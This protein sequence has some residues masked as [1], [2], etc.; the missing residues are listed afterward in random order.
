MQCIKMARFRIWPF[1]GAHWAIWGGHMGVRDA[2]RWNLASVTT[3]WPPQIAQCAPEKGKLLSIA[4]L[5]HCTS[6]IYVSEMENNR[7]YQG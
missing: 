4:I 6:L 2:Y 1:S 7:D 3:K 5:I